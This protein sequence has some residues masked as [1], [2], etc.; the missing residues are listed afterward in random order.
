MALPR[1][2]AAA[3]APFTAAGRAA[4]S[5]ASNT[6]RAALA[7]AAGPELLAIKTSLT[8]TVQGI[9]R[10]VRGEYSRLA[11]ANNASSE[12]L[13]DI[14]KNT[15][16]FSTSIDSLIDVVRSEVVPPLTTMGGYFQ[17]LAE[18]LSRQRALA[19]LPNTTNTQ[20]DDEPGIA[21]A[22]KGNGF[23]KK[24]FGFLGGLADGLWGLFKKFWLP[25]GL[26]GLLL[27][28][29]NAFLEGESDFAKRIKNAIDFSIIGGIGGF[30]VGGIPG[31]MVGGILGAA[32][33]AILD[34]KTV[35]RFTS[36]EGITLEISNI[37]GVTTATL[38]SLAT[39]A[40]VGALAG[41]LAGFFVGGVP[42][43]IVGLIIGAGLGAIIGTQFLPDSK[44]KEKIDKMI[45]SMLGFTVEEMKKRFNN[46]AEGA[47][48]GAVLGG[49]A[50]FLVGGPVGVIAGGIIGAGLGA[51]IGYKWEG[52]FP[53]KGSNFFNWELMKQALLGS[54]VGA[55]GWAAVGAA[56]GS[57][58]TPVGMI[59]GALIGAAVFYAVEWVDQQVE[60][61]FGSWSKMG[62]IVMGK[63]QS[64][65][66]SINNAVL[67][68]VENQKARL[69]YIIPFSGGKAG[70]LED[71]EES[72]KETEA[73]EAL[74]NKLLETLQNRMKAAEEAGEDFNPGSIE[75]ILLGNQL[76]VLESQLNAERIKRQ[77]IQDLIKEK[78]QEAAEFL[79]KMQTPGF[80][81][82]VGDQLRGLNY[83]LYIDPGM[84]Q[85]ISFT[86]NP[87][88]N[89]NS[90]N[91]GG[92]GQPVIM[93][94]NNQSYPQ[95][96]QNNSRQSVVNQS[97][98]TF[99]RRSGVPVAQMI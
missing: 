80:G 17:D 90:I 63:V 51:I 11:A 96:Y 70:A 86:P 82:I 44:D 97:S 59:A 65:F 15:S 22:A 53:E 9:V 99:I 91:G 78:E 12:S 27:L 57:V 55:V 29:K 33:G 77:A 4:G 45:A 49:A 14:K 7:A 23:G 98:S 75:N 5:A 47:G 58:A 19:G 28:A 67:R 38:K 18:K 74:R 62:D 13:D 25:L 41:S 73:L 71:I 24:L 37:F 16:G 8:S 46:A 69:L 10:S 85:T 88:L 52:W 93:I 40:T 6:A 95:V 87:R 26:A 30:L 20:S 36:L 2:A 3:A 84:K 83:P 56:I 76:R 35:E 39:S 79:Q 34:P 94:N 48:I 21:D 42:G 66:E 54:L 1:V 92:G 72:K 61:S 32:L 50:G 81:G 60:K 31:M 89:P 43:A 68:F 64:I